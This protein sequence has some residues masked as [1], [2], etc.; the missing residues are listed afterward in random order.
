MTYAALE[1]VRIVE[2]GRLVSAAYCTHLLR[3]FGASVDKV[4][5]PA[6]DPAREHGPFRDDIPHPERSGLCAYL[7]SGKRSIVLDIDRDGDRE[8]LEAML[9]TADVLVI[10]MPLAVRR[11]VAL[12][13][14]SV[15]AR[16]PHLVY[17]AISVFGDTGPRALD[18]A[19]TIDAYAASG[20]A[21][22]IGDPAREPLIIPLLQA[23]YQAGAHAASAVL[24]DFVGRRRAGGRGRGQAIDIA[25]ADILAAAAGTNAQIYLPFGAQR[26]ERAGTRAFGSGGPYPYVILPCKD[27]AVCLIGRARQEWARL[28]EAMGTP[29]WTQEPRYQNLQAMGR[30]Y[31]DEVDALVKPWLARHTRAELLELA[32]KHGFPL[33]PLR[34]MSEV[35]ASAHFSHRGFYRD[36]A[37]PDGPAL[38]VPGVPWQIAGR[39]RARAGPAPRLGE[40]SDAIRAEL[41]RACE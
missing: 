12:D 8:A 34:T 21:W 22:V 4:E 26:W 28:V 13:A 35:V 29:A 30:D 36:V 1:R 27:G 33:A 20:V 7:D 6:G 32:A 16:H 25:S 15:R 9:A 2:W 14:T 3:E 19:E 23:D 37:M 39:P 24:M 31:P 17:A 10:N 40:H 11:S 18:P 38:R 5:P 41:A